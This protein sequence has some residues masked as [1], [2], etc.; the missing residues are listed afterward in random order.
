MRLLAVCSLWLAAVAAARA[1][2]LGD[3]IKK[4]TDVP[5]YKSARWGLLVVDAKTGATV[6]EREADKLFLPASTT[7]LYTC[8]TALAELGPEF[9]FRTPVY[10]RGDVTD[11]VLKGDFFLIASGDLTMGGRRGKDGKTLFAD[12]DHTYAGSGLAQATLT[13]SN[14]LFALEDLAKQVKEIGIKEVDGEVFIDDRL[15]PKAKSSGSGPD[16]I[17]PVVINDNVVDVQ[18]APGKADGDPAV[19]TVR[20]ETVLI[21][22]D[23]MVRTGPADGKTS[24][25]IEPTGP[26]QFMIRGAVPAGGTPQVRIYAVDD[27][28][29]FARALFIDALRKAGVKVA[30]T[31]YRPRRTD[32]PDRATYS[33]MAKVAEYQSEP[34]ADVVKVTLKVSHNLYASTLPILVGLKHDHGSIQRGLEQQAKL[35]KGMGIDPATVSFAGGAG[36][37]QA[38]AVT[39]RTTVKLLRAMSAHQAAD[40]YF[41]ALPILGVDGTLAG[42]VPKDSPAYGKCRAK[43]GT[44]VW[45]D[46]QNDRMLMRAKALAGELTTAKGTKLYFAMFLNDVFLP[47]GGTTT[48]Q[49][50]VLGKVAEAIY[51][52]GP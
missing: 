17:S 1:D 25:T 14:P 32:L 49:G 6:Y 35:L 38:D 13:D 15:F 37:A 5:L 22:M 50:K 36:G 26:N 12:N 23:A 8:A 46:A 44:L 31:V 21:Q 33:R 42:I 43:T 30:A 52:H 29:A 24:V 39:P 16:A 45:H 3:A 4:I 10:R 41:D 9:R 34:L 2:E 27:A 48:Q 19:V 28:A 20:P 40:A 47:P 11:G 51:A 18:V 7:K